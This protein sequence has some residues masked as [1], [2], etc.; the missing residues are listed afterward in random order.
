MITASLTRPSEENLALWAL[1]FEEPEEE[2]RE[3][4]AALA[5][6]GATSL[7]LLRGDRIL[8]QGMLLPLTLTEGRGLYLYALC[9]HPAERGQGLLRRLI[10]EAVAFA[11][12]EGFFFLCLIPGDASLFEVY[13]RMGFTR[14]I[15]LGASVTPRK[16]RDFYLFRE[17]PSEAMTYASAE[18]VYPLFPPM[19]SPPLFRYA[20]ATVEA[21]IPLIGPR[22][23]VLSHRGDARRAYAVSP[24][25]SEDYRRQQGER[26]LLLPLSGEAPLAVPEPIPR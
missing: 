25:L 7:C 1:C 17:G 11:R 5:A 4:I 22:G 24:S 10:E 3:A 9:T 16:T 8:S 13:R 2:V 6:G 18:Q 12:R 26:M 20:I 21:A 14:E 23:A 19:L 15:P